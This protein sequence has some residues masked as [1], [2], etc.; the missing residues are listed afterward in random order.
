[1]TKRVY[2]FEANWPIRGCGMLFVAL[3][4]LLDASTCTAQV[5]S[6]LSES[7]KNVDPNEPRKITIYPMARSTPALKITL[8][9]PEADLVDGNAAVLYGKAVSENNHT[10]FNETASS[11][12]WSRFGELI[13]MP[14][15][16][17]LKQ[18]EAVKYIDSDGVHSYFRQA[19][20][21]R[22]CDWQL[23]IGKQP[24]V[25]ILLPEYQQLRWSA[26][27][28]YL[29]AR[30]QMARGEK[31]KAIESIQNLYAMARHAGEGPLVANLVGVA[32]AEMANDAVLEL[33]QQ[34][35]TP[36][37]YW[38]VTFLPDPILD[39]HRIADLDRNHFRLSVLFS[40]NDVEYNN[41]P[42]FWLERLAESKFYWDPKY[43]RI[44]ESTDNVD[45]DFWAYSIGLSGYTAAKEILLKNGFANEKINNMPVAK[46]LVLAMWHE[47][48]NLSDE[49]A[50]L[51]GLPYY[52]A[53]KLRG[54]STMSTSSLDFFVN[55]SYPVFEPVHRAI[56]RL[57]RS[58][59]VIRII[60]ALRQYAAEHDGSLP[61][62]LDQ[63]SETPI[64]L[65]PMRGDSFLF[66][67]KTSANGTIATLRTRDARVPRQFN[68]EI[69]VSH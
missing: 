2:Q 41:D 15:P 40:D 9:P 11:L 35:D 46:A 10:F 21:Y 56:T 65:D 16:E 3:I 22:H 27:L 63:I 45:P 1:M 44:P 29:R 42:K 12:V 61:A 69:V 17:L 50:K 34:P 6:S 43:Y 60:E 59:D 37:L 18:T 52:E 68:F 48:V 49:H 26:R 64:P 66:E 36:N 51:L 33:I 53:A 4:C 38:A 30:I 55:D 62:S 8:L 24:L 54:N 58:V 13:A 39:L 23:P 25:S 19:A 5:I 31:S 7:S 14:L 67:T 32:I 47:S 28:V 57:R 20:L